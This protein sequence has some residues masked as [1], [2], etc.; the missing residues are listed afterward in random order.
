MRNEELN[1]FNLINDIKKQDY[2]K[3]KWELVIVNDHSTDN[4]LNIA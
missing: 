4:S 3:K 2:P 1:I